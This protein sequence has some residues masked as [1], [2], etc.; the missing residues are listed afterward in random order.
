MIEQRHNFIS[1]ESQETNW[2]TLTV[3]EEEPV[4]IQQ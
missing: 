2:F 4:A 3:Q 1:F